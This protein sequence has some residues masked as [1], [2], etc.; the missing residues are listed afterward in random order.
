MIKA[1]EKINDLT[2]TGVLRKLTNTYVLAKLHL[3]IYAL[4]DLSVLSKIFKTYAINFT[5]NENEPSKCR[6]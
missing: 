5:K 3:F 1:L 6:T 4:P 2:T